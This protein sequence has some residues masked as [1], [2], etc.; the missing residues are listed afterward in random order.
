MEEIQRDVEVK[1]STSQGGSGADGSFRI[2]FTAST[3]EVS[4]TVSGSGQIL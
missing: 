2:E 4:T 3:K 1:T